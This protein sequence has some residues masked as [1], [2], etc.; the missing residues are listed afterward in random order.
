MRD[1]AARGHPVHLARPDH[2]LDAEA[3]A[4]RD[5]S[6]EE[7]A[8]GGEADMRVRPDVG[9][10]ELFGRQ[11]QRPGMVEEDE[12]P[13]HAPLAERQDAADGK[14]TAEIGASRVDD[15]IEH[16]PVKPEDRA[17]AGRASAGS[18]GR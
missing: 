17:G 11:V 10:A 2:L 4:M 7:I 1:A 12:R 9:L 16:R 5:F 13:D 3:V 14:A 6:A 18:L 15:E 8:D